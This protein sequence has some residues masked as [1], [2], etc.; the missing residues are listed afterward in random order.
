MFPTSSATVPSTFSAYMAEHDIPADHENLDGWRRVW[1]N[2]LEVEA[3]TP[4]VM[5]PCPRWCTLPADHPYPSY[6]VGAD[7]P[8]THLRD[9]VGFT[10]ERVQVDA[11]ERNTGGT[12][13]VDVPTAFVNVEDDLDAAAVRAF[14]ADLLRAA[15]ELDRI[16]R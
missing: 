12:V 14:A 15:D 1:R 13:T 2:E 10:A 5:P 8:M 7:L 16:T 3:S 4:T 6:D 9:H 11:T